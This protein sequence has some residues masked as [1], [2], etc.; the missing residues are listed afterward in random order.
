VEDATGQALTYVGRVRRG[1]QD[2][3]QLSLWLTA[4]SVRSGA[5][6]HLVR[7]AERLLGAGCD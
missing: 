7:L 2:P 1:L 3:C 6:A 4:D 5:A